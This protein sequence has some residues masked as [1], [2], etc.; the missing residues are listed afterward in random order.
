MNHGVRMAIGWNLRPAVGFS[1]FFWLI[2]F[3]FISFPLLILTWVLF[4]RARHPPSLLIAFE[5]WLLLTFSLMD[6]FPVP[7]GWPADRSIGDGLTS[8][9]NARSRKA[10]RS[11]SGRASR[12]QASNPSTTWLVIYY[13]VRDDEEEIWKL[14]SMTL[15][16]DSEH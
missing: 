1:S 6:I 14:C 8:S 13:P 3:R 12:N 15:D 11:D 16:S 5:F 10:R 9:G 7:R 2:A 4:L